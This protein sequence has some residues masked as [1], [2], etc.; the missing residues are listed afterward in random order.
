[1]QRNAR[2][3]AQMQLS[4]L[5]YRQLDDFQFERLIDAL[6]LVCHGL[7]S[8]LDASGS[9]RLPRHRIVTGYFSRY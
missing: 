9:S 3:V 2:R 7:L 4:L 1:M 5:L 8:M 6:N